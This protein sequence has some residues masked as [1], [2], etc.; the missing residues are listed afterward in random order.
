MPFHLTPEVCG[1]PDFKIIDID[2]KAAAVELQK[3]VVRG[4]KLTGVSLDQIN[5]NV[6][7]KPFPPNVTAKEY[8]KLNE[9]FKADKAEAK[10]KVEESEKGKEP[11]GD[12]SDEDEDLDSDK[13]RDGITLTWLLEHGMKF[14]D[15][16]VWLA[17]GKPKDYPLRV[18]PTL[19]KDKITPRLDVAR[20]VFYNYFFLLT[21][22]RY[23]A[24]PG[25]TN[26]PRVA[27]FLVTIMGLAEDQSVYVS[28]ICSFAPQLYNPEW[29]KLV[30]FKGLS[31]EVFLRFGLGV[32]G[33]RYFSPFKLYSCKPD[34]DQALK[35]AYT[36]AQTV[37][38]APPSWDIHPLTRKPDV[39]TKRGNLNKNL[40]NL[41]LEVFTEE[42]IT[43]MVAKKVIFEKPVHQ[44]AHCNYKTW[45]ETD[46][47]SGSAVIF[48]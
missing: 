37:A 12:E 14:F 6:S 11:E 33:Y 27:D 24:G 9:K 43:E 30:H 48:R 8:E 39:L 45:S 41:I 21:Q 28:R 15:A 35:S 47:I 26:K 42:Q 22:A 36:F 18:D 23:P 17:A 29:V 1:K 4:S 40:G 25:E 31:H 16:M 13:I 5:T 38:K 32:A 19:T 34:V 2:P 3:Y 10:S 44:A 20:A 46:D 7:E